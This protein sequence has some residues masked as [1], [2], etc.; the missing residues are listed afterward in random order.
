MVESS[1]AVLAR[2]G[3]ADARGMVLD[4]SVTIDEDM[5]AKQRAVLGQTRLQPPQQEQS[6]SQTCAS[7]DDLE[8]SS[9]TMF[10]QAG[11]NLALGAI[12]DMDDDELIKQQ[13]ARR[14]CPHSFV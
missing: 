8:M 6:G 7:Q 11:Q 1:T 9:T 5:L 3:Q 12:L 14:L 4:D 10:A 2:K 13:A